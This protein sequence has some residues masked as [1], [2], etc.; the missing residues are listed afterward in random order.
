MQ[1]ALGSVDCA[2]AQ[3][4]L[5]KVK[6][7]QFRFTIQTA[8]RELKLR[9]HSAADYDAWIAALRPHASVPAEA[10]AASSPGQGGGSVT[11]PDKNR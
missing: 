9:A 11:S 3:V 5:K 1:P 10:A 7:E 4:F 6:G 2:S 8:Q